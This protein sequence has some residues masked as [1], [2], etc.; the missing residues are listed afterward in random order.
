MIAYSG[1][2][3]VVMVKSAATESGRFC[4]VDVHRRDGQLTYRDVARVML[5]LYAHSAWKR[6]VREMYRRTV[7]GQQL[8][9]GDSP[10]TFMSA[11]DPAQHAS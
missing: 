10:F 3:L 6:E 1:F 8:G 4:W 7:E 9:A 2:G 5:E 11:V